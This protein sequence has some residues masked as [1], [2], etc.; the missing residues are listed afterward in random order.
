MRCPDCGKFVSQEQADP[1]LD[2]S[3]EHDE[4]GDA[5]LTGNVTC[6]LNC[7]DCGTTLK[8]ATLDVEEIIPIHHVESDGAEPPGG[9][10]GATPVDG[11][12]REECELTLES[13]SAEASSR[14]EGRGRGTKTWYGAEITVHVTCSCGADASHT[15]TV[16][17]QASG[18]EEVC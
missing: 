1:E 12:K 2:L 15:F 5:I 13:E 4:D 7:A 14:S 17:E 11:K 10:Q 18:F 6:D 8:Q 3:V 9:W 16:D